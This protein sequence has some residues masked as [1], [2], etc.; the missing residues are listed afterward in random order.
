MNWGILEAGKQL[1][2]SLK[3]GPTRDGTGEVEAILDGNNHNGD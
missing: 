2:A 1:E 3:E